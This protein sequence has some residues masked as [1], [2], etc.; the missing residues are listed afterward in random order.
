MVPCPPTSELCWFVQVGKQQACQP[1][2]IDSPMLCSVRLTS[3]PRAHSRTSCGN[4]GG[5][6]AGDRREGR[7]AALTLLSGIAVHAAPAFCVGRVS[8]ANRRQFDDDSA[9]I[10][11]VAGAQGLCGR[12]SAPRGR[13]RGASHGCRCTSTSDRDLRKWGFRAGGSPLPASRRM[14]RRLVQ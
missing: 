12:P 2:K 3:S 5:W 7:W 6:V 11:A 13:P 1:R 8:R 10:C 14:Q 9:R 4:S